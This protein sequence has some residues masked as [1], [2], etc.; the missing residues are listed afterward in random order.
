MKRLAG[1][2]TPC[3]KG[4]LEAILVLLYITEDNL[5]IQK[6]VAFDGLLDH[7]LGIIKSNGVVSDD[8]AVYD[9]LRL[10]LKL[11]ERNPS[12]QV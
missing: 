9:S 12:V 2:S 5:E 6:V 4:I 10:M 7:I 3:P 11:I 8:I 1:L